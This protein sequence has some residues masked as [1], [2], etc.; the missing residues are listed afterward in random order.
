MPLSSVSTTRAAV[1][2]APLH[3]SGGAETLTGTGGDQLIGI[4]TLNGFNSRR[5]DE[6]E[7]GDLLAGF[8]EESST[9]WADLLG[10]RCLGGV[11]RCRFECWRRAF[12]VVASLPGRQW[13]QN[14][15]AEVRWQS[16]RQIMDVRFGVDVCAGRRAEREAAWELATALDEAIRADSFAAHL[17]EADPDRA[18]LLSSPISSGRPAVKGDWTE[19]VAKGFERGDASRYNPGFHREGDTRFEASVRGDATWATG[20]DIVALLGHALDF[21]A[22]SLAAS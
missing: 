1:R 11:H 16:A 7:G 14:A 6:S 8:I 13:G 17:R 2:T 10:G 15:I 18:E 21:L 9:R 5:V 22:E 4:V 3:I 20:P 12:P 19:I